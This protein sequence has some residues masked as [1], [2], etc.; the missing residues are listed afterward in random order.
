MPKPSANPPKAVDP[1]RTE[2]IEVASSVP[3]PGTLRR[4]A[5]TPAELEESEYP[6][7][8]NVYFAYLYGGKDGLVRVLLLTHTDPDFKPVK[9]CLDRARFDEVKKGSYIEE[10][11][12][13]W[14]LYTRL[15][16]FRARLPGKGTM[17][18]YSPPF[19]DM[20][21]PGLRRSGLL[22]DPRSTSH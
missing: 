16:P 4:D 21:F 3:Q 6:G 10:A 20:S 13:D 7:D 19:L 12:K 9:L 8:P 18:R 14:P 15:A 2:P 1:G 11:P 17:V 22:Y 5:G